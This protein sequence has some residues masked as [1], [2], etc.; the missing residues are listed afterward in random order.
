MENHPYAVHYERLLPALISKVEEFRLY[1]Y[2][3]A[4]VSTLWECL[5]KKKWKKTDEERTFARLVG[6]ILSVKPGDYMNYTQVAAFK[7][8]QWG[9]PLSDDELD[10]LFDRPKDRE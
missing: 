1:G 3:S 5:L 6:D 4:N 2:D 10:A 8:P 7:T 9:A